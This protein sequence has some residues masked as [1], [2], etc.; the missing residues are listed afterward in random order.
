MGVGGNGTIAGASC[1][2]VEVAGI[3]EHYE[4]ERETD[5]LQYGQGFGGSVERHSVMYLRC[6]HFITVAIGLEDA[7]IVS[8]TEEPRRE[9]RLW[10]DR[11]RH[12][13]SQSA[14]A[15]CQVFS[16]ALGKPLHH[17]VSVGLGKCNLLRSVQRM[18]Y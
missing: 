12:R 13:S 5:R 17:R 2:T 6:L 4:R 16:L 8:A 15:T 10:N 18:H 14:C 11:Q 9:Y 3:D 7:I 1:V